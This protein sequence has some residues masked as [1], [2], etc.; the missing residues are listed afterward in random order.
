M[1]QYNKVKK[2]ELNE[3]KGRRIE[4]VNDCKEDKEDNDD[5]Q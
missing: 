3:Q 1:S 2:K 5:K 4:E